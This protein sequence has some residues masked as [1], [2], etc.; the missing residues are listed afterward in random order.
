MVAMA[1]QR[2]A[3]QARGSDHLFVAGTLARLSQVEVGAQPDTFACTPDGRR[4]L[5]AD[6]GEPP[7]CGPGHTD[8]KA[9]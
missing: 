6:E 5:V 8:P 4:V 3:V 2:E 9:G 1:E 7:G